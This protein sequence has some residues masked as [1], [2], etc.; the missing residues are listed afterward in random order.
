MNLADFI[1]ELQKLE[2]TEQG[3]DVR[4]YVQYRAAGEEFREELAVLKVE[5]RAITF[6]QSQAVPSPLPLISSPRKDSYDRKTSSKFGPS[7][8]VQNERKTA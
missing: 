4:F 3:K 8:G 1:R 6:T 7:A 2:S 5:S